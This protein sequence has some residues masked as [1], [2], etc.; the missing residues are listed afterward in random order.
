MFNSDGGTELIFRVDG[1][2]TR[3]I[4]L[5]KKLLPAWTDIVFR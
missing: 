2:T 3:A 1:R 4:D 5:E